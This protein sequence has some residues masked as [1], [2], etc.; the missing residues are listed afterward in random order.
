MRDVSHIRPELRLQRHR[1]SAC[2]RGSHDYGEA[3]AVG[4]GITRQVCQTCGVVTIDLSQAD[5][6]TTP[7]I[8]TLNTIFAMTSKRPSKL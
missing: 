1:R 8:P 3:Q 5:E 4:A 6:L 7:L 2:R